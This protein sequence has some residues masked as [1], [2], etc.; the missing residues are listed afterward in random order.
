MERV[1]KEERDM[2]TEEMISNY[3]KALKKSFNAACFDIDGT[4]TSVGSVSVDSKAV[5]MMANLL[6]K[7]IPVI[8]VTGRGETGL[9]DFIEEV[10]ESLVKEYYLN[11][12]ELS[13][14]YALINDGARYLVTN[15][16]K[17]DELFNEVRY[18]S[19]NEDIEQLKS[20]KE[21]MMNVYKDTINKMCDISYSEDKEN[22]LLINM[23]FVFKEN[24]DEL[25]NRFVTFID[26]FIK[27]NN[28]DAL[29]ITRGVYKGRV[30][31]PRASMIR[32]GDCGDKL[33]N[34]YAML[35]CPEGFSVDKF[36]GKVNACFPVMDDDLNLIKGVLGTVYLMNKVNINKSEY[37]KKLVKQLGICSMYKFKLYFKNY[38]VKFIELEDFELKVL[39]ENKKEIEDLCKDKINDYMIYKVELLKDEEVIGYYDDSEC[40][41]D[42]GRIG[43]LVYD[44]NTGDIIS[45]SEEV[46]GVQ[47]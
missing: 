27:V 20:F 25:I 6:K 38:N 35:D 44:I 42:D 24:N 10:K 17:D 28:F 7:E 21:F 3:K 34:D 15:K 46:S 19:S 11:E 8:I 23:R 26:S 9:K 31:I 47:L 33:G 14:L 40:L 30:V 12:N 13:S 1:V 22:N 2:I 45:F 43:H 5:E 32:V 36:S 37:T 18:I 29:N 39:N 41:I 16:E 4:L